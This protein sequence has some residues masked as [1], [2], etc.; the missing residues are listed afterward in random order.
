ML[1]PTALLGHK[2][3]DRINGAVSAVQATVTQLQRLPASSGAKWLWPRVA[4]PGWRLTIRDL[5]PGV[6]S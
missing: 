1:F 5:R 3:H 4:R 2:E 6:V